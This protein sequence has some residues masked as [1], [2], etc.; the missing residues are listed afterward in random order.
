MTDLQL[1]FLALRPV[2]ENQNISTV[3]IATKVL[4]SPALAST[5]QLFSTI[6]LT[7]SI[8]CCHGTYEL[9]KYTIKVEEK[10][11]TCFLASLPWTTVS[12]GTEAKIETM[13]KGCHME[14]G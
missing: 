6:T 11:D 14:A 8:L 2:P 12:L 5:L 13:G 1:L 9:Q 3:A 4:L 7:L 10:C